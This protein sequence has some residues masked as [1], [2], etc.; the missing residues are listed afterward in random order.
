MLKYAQ[1]QQNPQNQRINAAFCGFMSEC[2]KK[3]TN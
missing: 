1:K 3:D 2:Y